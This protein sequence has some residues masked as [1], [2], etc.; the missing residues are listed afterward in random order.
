MGHRPVY[1]IPKALKWLA[2]F[3]S[4]EVIELN[5]FAAQGYR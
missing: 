1:A 4:I 2:E 5:G 3:G